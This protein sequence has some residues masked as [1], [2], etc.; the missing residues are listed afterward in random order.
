ML[1]FFVD[2]IRLFSRGSRDV[3]F[4]ILGSLGRAR[5]FR[6]RGP[7]GNFGQKVVRA[8]C[9]FFLD[10]W[11]FSCGSLFLSF[12]NKKID[13]T[14]MEKHRFFVVVFVPRALEKKSVFACP[15]HVGAHMS[16]GFFRLGDPHDNIGFYG[17][18]CKFTLCRFLE[19]YS[20]KP[21]NVQ[22]TAS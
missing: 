21:K 20:K 2:K 13:E 4:P 10:F 14:S 6:E 1:A 15:P 22:K 17:V 16:P 18:F 11:R 12:F 5:D 3:F 8:H 19:T 9:F 7:E